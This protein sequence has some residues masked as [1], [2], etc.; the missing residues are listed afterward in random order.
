MACYELMVHLHSICISLLALMLD[1]SLIVTGSLERALQMIYGDNINVRLLRLS[2]PQR[3]VWKHLQQ[4]QLA[5]DFQVNFSSKLM[6]HQTTN[7]PIQIDFFSPSLKLGI[8]YHGGQH[9]AETHRGSFERQQERDQ[10]KRIQCHRTGITLI[11]IPFY[12]WNNKSLTLLRYIQEKRPDIVF[13]RHLGR[14]YLHSSSDSIYIDKD[15]S[16]IS[17]TQLKHMRINLLKAVDWKYG[18]DPQGW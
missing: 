13:A 9:Y 6:V 1:M 15:N 17:S 12:Q 16:L 7:K 3:Q 10:E 2:S 4:L 14:F 8:E 11:E 5:S 18:Q